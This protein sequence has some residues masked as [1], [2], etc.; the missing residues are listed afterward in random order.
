MRQEK[1][2]DF[3]KVACRVTNG[4]AKSRRMKDRWKRTARDQSP[5]LVKE[6]VSY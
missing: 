6:R 2:K 1:N 4:E 5:F 3:K